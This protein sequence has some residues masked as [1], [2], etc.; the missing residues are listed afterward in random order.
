MSPSLRRRSSLCLSTRP[1]HSS[2]RKRPPKRSR[3][4]PRII[5]PSTL[6]GSSLFACHPDPCLPV[7][8]Y[9]HTVIGHPS[10][11]I[12]PRPLGLNSVCQLGLF[13]HSILS[14]SPQLSSDRQLL[15]SL[16]V[17]VPGFIFVPTQRRIIDTGTSINNF[18]IT[19]I[20]LS[21]PT[22]ATTHFLTLHHHNHACFF[23]ICP[24]HHG[25]FGMSPLCLCSAGLLVCVSPFVSPL[26]IVC[27][28]LSRSVCA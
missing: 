23:G 19:L 15:L 22:S 17:A 16:P 26:P 6:P 3:S 20:H 25:P 21:H 7:S 28:C 2:P 1:S 14:P 8:S 4:E 18:R 27:L 9:S 11:S 13:S 10:T 12:H 5:S 24:A